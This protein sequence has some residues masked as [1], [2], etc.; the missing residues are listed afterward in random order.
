MGHSTRGFRR[1]YFNPDEEWEAQWEN[2]EEEDWVDN[3]RTKGLKTESSGMR[4]TSYE[5][6]EWKNY[7]IAEYIDIEVVEREP[8]PKRVA[9][10]QPNFHKGYNPKQ[11]YSKSGGKRNFNQR[12]R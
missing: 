10:H 12:R 1:K 7:Y 8:P 5:W 6:Y 9:K 4:F 2:I 11:N 3:P